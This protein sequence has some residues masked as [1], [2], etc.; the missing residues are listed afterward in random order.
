[1]AGKKFSTSLLDSAKSRERQVRER[2]RESILSSLLDALV[3]SPVRVDEAIVFGS[4]ISA[5]D[6]DDKSDIDVAVPTLTP[7]DYWTL[8]VYL[9]NTTGREV[10]LLEIETCRFIDAI[11]KKGLRWTSQ[12]S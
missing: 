6:F 5:Y 2:R 10:D 4:L 1:M 3:N 8:K 11:V 9:E 12:R 7:R